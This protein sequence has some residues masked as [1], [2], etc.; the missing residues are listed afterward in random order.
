MIVSLGLAL[1]PLGADGAAQE[2]AQAYRETSRRVLARALA[3]DGAWT[4]LE[5]LTTRIGHRLSGSAALDAAIAWAHAGM[6]GEGLDG[7]RLH[8][9][10][11][12]RIATDNPERL[13]RSA[14]EHRLICAAIRDRDGA[15]AASAT[16]V[17]LRA[18][19]TTIL[20]TLAARDAAPTQKGR[21]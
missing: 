5:H 15:L 8:L 13:V 20:D 18:S 3:D 10:R 9:T 6:T 12:R 11:A 7:V 2:V 14:D 4:K 1:A 19:L 16:T 17:H 21:A